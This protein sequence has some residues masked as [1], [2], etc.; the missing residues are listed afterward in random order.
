MIAEP[1]PPEPTPEASGLIELEL[2]N[3]RRL[4]ISG[5]YDPDATA[6]LVR[7]LT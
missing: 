4:R 5:G 6:R 2:A 1:T 7:H 3:G